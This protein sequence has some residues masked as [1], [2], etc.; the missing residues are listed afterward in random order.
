MKERWK[1]AL[2]AVNEIRDILKNS[3]FK[4]NKTNLTNLLYGINSIGSKVLANN[5]INP[6]E[7]LTLYEKY[8]G[9]SKNLGLLNYA[10]KAIKNG[11]KLTPESAM[12][13]TALVNLNYIR[14]I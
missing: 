11:G 4:A 7:A 13:L 10:Q 12:T 6:T 1:E 2:I 3:D 9:S 14:T 5:G 8:I